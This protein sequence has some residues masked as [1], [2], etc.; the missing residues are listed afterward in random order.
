MTKH[1]ELVSEAKVAIEKIFNDTSV[2]KKE[3]FDSLEDIAVDLDNMIN[4]LADE[5]Q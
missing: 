5:F 2:S 4:C 1:S 3:I